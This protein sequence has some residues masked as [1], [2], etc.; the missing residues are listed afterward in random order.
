MPPSLYIRRIVDRISSR[1]R[2]G[3]SR[4]YTI[5]FLG[6]D[7]CGKTTLL[8]CLSGENGL[9]ETIPAL[10]LTLET[11]M[12]RLQGVS[13]APITFR[14]WDVG[15]SEKRL[16]AAF[17]AHCTETRDADAL[18][19]LVDSSAQGWRDDSV[20]QFRYY[21]ENL[22]YP[23]I[24]TKNGI[25]ILILATRNDLPN[26]FTA[27]EVQDRFT[28]M[29]PGRNVFT[30]ALS[31]FTDSLIPPALPAALRWLLDSA[32]NARAGRPPPASP[33]EDPL[34]PP[35]LAIKLAAWVSRAKADTSAAQFLSQFEHASL[36]AW[37]HYI[38]IRAVY[39][40]L[41]AFG[42]HK[43]RDLVLQGLE[44]GDRARGR[45]FNVTRTY[46]WIQVV[47][48][49]ICGMPAVP[50]PADIS[51]GSSSTSL[52]AYLEFLLLNSFVV[53]EELWT[54]YYSR[55]VMTSP[56]AR[57]RMV[58][59]D[60]RRLPNLVGRDVVSPSLKLVGTM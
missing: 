14:S 46:F 21:V 33:G 9:V 1:T 55:E 31:T 30:T 8:R 12:V 32:E 41:T 19:W 47:H 15:R 34:S 18:I 45:P 51:A 10:G 6:L 17:L 16:P 54:E 53:D 4:G 58:L 48:F 13:D 56:K 24:N 5:A 52:A 38:T 44:R 60:K 2:S 57:A 25:P 37:D 20:M 43:G 3:S 7:G 49:C 26:A 35:A 50:A 28:F 42:R 29:A 11:A 36:P 23:N 27:S 22:K 39:S 40:L 59:P